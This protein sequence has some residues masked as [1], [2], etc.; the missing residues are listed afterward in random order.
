L[1]REPAA[2]SLNTSSGWSAA[3]K[4][5]LAINQTE[6]GTILIVISPLISRGWRLRNTSNDG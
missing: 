4:A 6:R 2:R 3:N 1:G 5:T